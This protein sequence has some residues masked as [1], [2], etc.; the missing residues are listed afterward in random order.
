MDKK[1]TII[2]VSLLIAAF[3]LMYFGPKPTAPSTAQP[4]PDVTRAVGSNQAPSAG[5][6]GST[7]P[8]D[9]AY[10]AVYREVS[11][12]KTIALRNDMVEFR[13]TNYGGAIKECAVRGYDADK[14]RK[15]EPY[16]INRLH[17]DPSLAIVDFPGLDR[18]SAYEL[19]SSSPTEAVFRAVFENRIE[20]VRRYSIAPGS[21]D[22]RS[23]PY[24]LRYETVFRNLTEQSL[25]LPRIQMSV[26]TAAPL[27]A[28]DYGLYLS[29]GY[30]SG[31]KT[32][33]VKR[34]SLEGGGMLSWVGMG[35]K[36]PIPFIETAAS[37]SWASVQNQFFVSI[38]TPDQPGSSLVS[39]RVELPSFPGSTKP[40]IGM[41][42]VARFDL[43]VL[44]PKGEAR[45][46]GSF[47]AGPKEYTRLSNAEIFKLDQ[48]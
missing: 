28:E 3:A 11:E 26:G 48:D 20:V 10:A 35:S 34:S 46:S 12:A 5:T 17:A 40:A 30:N 21:G 43:P 19:V 14:A 7:M 23:D 1:N 31:G 15:G 9:T 13:L 4:S 33:I 32:S 25:P 18:N 47:Y 29:N 44:A 37:I 42:G 36:D 24:Q 2:G 45:L 8:R 16:V 41:T 38:L 39:R 27:N 6:S 22:V